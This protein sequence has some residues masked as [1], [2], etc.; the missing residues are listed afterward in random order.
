MVTE[1]RVLNCRE[2]DAEYDGCWVL[3][4]KR[5]FPPEEDTGYIV[6]CGDGTPEDWKSLMEIQC[7]KYHGE[8]ILM[9]G[10]IPKDGDFPYNGPI[11][12]V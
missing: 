7:G 8:V 11:E 1:K 2:V 3:F 12:I 4:D 9:K 5:D 6:A 10:W